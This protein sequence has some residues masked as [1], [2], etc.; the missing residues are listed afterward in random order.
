MDDI[1]T[2]LETIKQRIDSACNKAGRNPNEVKLLLATKT[3]VPQR[4]IE[5]INAG[6]TLI[7]EN[8]VQ[9]IKEKFDA[10]KVVQHQ[11]HFIGHLQTNKIKDII[12]YGVACVES[13]D[14]LELA[15]KLHNRLS[16]EGK[17]MDILIQVNTSGEESK[18]G[19]EPQ[20]AVELAKQIAP[21]KSLKIKGLMTIGLFSAETEKVRKCFKLLA[22]LRNEIRNLNLPD[23][24]M[25]ELSMG[26]S[27]DLETA[28]E[29]GA[30]IVRVGTAV[31][32]HRIYPDSYYWPEKK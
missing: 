2:N 19:V 31:F 20:K 13:V 30:T 8:K 14:R 4:I 16:T 3:V 24:E 7:G 25:N 29:E 15:E 27:G 32:G 18:F 11:K 12:R 6:Y 22:S 5:A 10:L 17:K 23:V 1:R 9:E 26:M 28:I 21:L